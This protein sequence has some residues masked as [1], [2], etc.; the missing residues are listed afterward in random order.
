M[1]A[2]G[3]SSTGGAAEHSMRVLKQKEIVDLLRAEVKKAGSQEAWAKKAG[4]QRTAVNKVLHGKK[5]PSKS[6]I[7]ALGLRIV[8][9]SD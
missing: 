8:V 2:V 5:P 1:R 9:V 4:L 6:I 7:F 3:G